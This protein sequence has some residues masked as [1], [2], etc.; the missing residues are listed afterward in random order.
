MFNSILNPKEI[1]LKETY[2]AGFKIYKENFKKIVIITILLTFPVDLISTMLNVFSV[3]IGNSLDMDMISKSPEI[4]YQNPL[5]LESIMKVIIYFLIFIVV[6]VIFLP[7]GIMAIA[8]LS[9][10]YVYGR[11]VN[12]QEAVVFSFS[13]SFQMILVSII[14]ALCIGVCSLFI[15]PGIYISILWY[16]YIYSV[17]LAGKN[18]INALNYSMYLTRRRWL[19]TFIFVIVTFSISYL[20]NILVV[21]VVDAFYF[22]IPNDFLYTIISRVLISIVSGIFYC[23]T[24]VYFLN[25]EIVVKAETII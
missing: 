24:T 22:L 21:S 17:S 25:R 20:A 13:R 3:N 12:Y 11:S 18:H 6:Q 14:N 10:S 9:K 5:I 1:T 19:K 2:F 8:Y 16:F 15:I 4:I 7:F 23:S